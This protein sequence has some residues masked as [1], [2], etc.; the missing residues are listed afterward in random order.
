MLL[1]QIHLKNFRC[2]SDAVFHF[3]G[4]LI[5]IEGLN[6]SGKSSL[7]EALHYLCYM[8]SF[9]THSPRELLETGQD[10]F[11]L[12]A[13]FDAPA[14]NQISNEVQ[15]GFSGKKRMVK[16]NQKA[17][18]SYKELMDF[19]RIV[20]VT[21]DDLGLIH[22]SP[23]MRRFFIDQAL[24]LYNPEYATVLRS[25][26][27]IV[28][29]R[30]RLLQQRTYDL[31]SYQLWTTQLWNMSRQIQLMRCEALQSLEQETNRM[32][33]HYF[34]ENLSVSFEY[35]PR[36]VGFHETLDEFLAQGGLAQEEA[37]YGYSLFGAHLDDIIIKFQDKKSKTYSS[38][39]QQKLVVLLIKIAQAKELLSKK[40]AAI[41]LLD[42]F[43]TD[44]D[45]GRI[46]ILL[47][48]LLDLKLQ[49]IF[50]CPTVPHFLGE[51]LVSKGA[52]RVKLTH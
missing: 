50:T 8:R 22:G 43:M 11:F 25:F 19:Y 15:V 45:G 24:V 33:A 4:P 34:E 14:D 47:N 28:D 46:N 44:F 20:T 13:I 30:N 26:R 7:L 48:V 10:S 9:R 17:I 38:R 3:N 6:G 52:F 40:G 1:T 31:D 41:F 35:K 36:R 18:S 29:H 37:R 2:F 51:L 23:E 5:L 27:H 12:K 49:L 39:G 32:L 16:I 21:E 42:D